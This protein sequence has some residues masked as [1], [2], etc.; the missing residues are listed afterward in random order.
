MQAAS[1]LSPTFTLNATKLKSPKCPRIKVQ[2]LNVRAQ[3]WTT[4]TCTKEFSWAASPIFRS[5]VFGLHLTVALFLFQEEQIHGKII[6]IF[7]H[8]ECPRGPSAAGALGI[9][10]W[11]GPHAKG[12]C[13]RASSTLLLGRVSLPRGHDRA[14]SAP[15]ACRKYLWTFPQ[16][17]RLEIDVYRR[18]EGEKKL[19]VNRGNYVSVSLFL[20]FQ[21]SAR[22]FSSSPV[23]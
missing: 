21:G 23:N 9:S 7:W 13:W 2:K 8:R 14:L 12:P 15:S 22:K 16:W 17:S 5:S 1:Y 10:Q 6:V 20:E 3:E 11:N 4:F 18:I 19:Q